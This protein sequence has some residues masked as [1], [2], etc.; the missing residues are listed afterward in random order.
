MVKTA[1]PRRTR[2]VHIRQIRVAIENP[3]RNAAA[4]RNG[5][6]ETWASGHRLASTERLAVDRQ[7]IT[8]TFVGACPVCNAPALRSIV[9]VDS[10]AVKQ[11]EG[12][13]S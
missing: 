8:T 4:S 13:M 2:Y 7:G 6:S 5:H 3:Y 10:M 9:A 12:P 11:R 1:R